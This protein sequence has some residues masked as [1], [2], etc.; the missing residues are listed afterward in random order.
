MPGAASFLLLALTEPH[1]LLL[2]QPYSLLPFSGVS[3]GRIGL[4]MPRLPGHFSRPKIAQM[5]PY[6]LYVHLYYWTFGTT[7]F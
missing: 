4:G 5:Q 6:N 7:C 3:H 2:R 1:L